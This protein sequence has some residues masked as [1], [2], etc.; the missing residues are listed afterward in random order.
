MGWDKCPQV[1]AIEAKYRRAG[2]MNWDTKRVARLAIRLKMSVPELLAWAGVLDQH[3]V[4]LF[5]VKGEWPLSVTIHLAK[6]EAM[7]A[8]SM[9]PDAQDTLAGV[10]LDR[11]KAS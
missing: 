11:V 2:F 6:L 7:H 5:W 9:A 10:I 1:L 4:R 3:I 8:Q